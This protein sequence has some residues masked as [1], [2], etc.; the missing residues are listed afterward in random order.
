MQEKGRE[1]ESEGM[2]LDEKGSKRSAGMKLGDEAWSATTREERKTRGGTYDSIEWGHICR[3]VLCGIL[4]SSASSDL[5][6]ATSKPSRRKE[7]AKWTK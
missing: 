3:V 4:H 2:K 5:L 6:D 7:R 1:Q